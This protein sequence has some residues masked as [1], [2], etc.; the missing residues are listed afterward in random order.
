[1]YC[2]QIDLKFT[3]A[4]LNSFHRI[5]RIYS[6]A[7]SLRF[8]KYLNNNCKKMSS[9]KISIERGV[10]NVQSYVQTNSIITTQRCYRSTY[11]PPA[12]SGDSIRK[13]HNHFILFGTV[14]DRQRSETPSVSSDD[15]R[16]FENAFDENPRLSTENAEHEL[17]IPRFIIRDVLRKKLKMFL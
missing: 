4:A 1:M 17:R 11:G 15:V 13:W 2:L 8:K 16:E 7:Y 3:W 10:A 9:S 6:C 14:G 12:S 5:R